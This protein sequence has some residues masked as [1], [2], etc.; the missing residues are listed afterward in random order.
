LIDYD[1]EMSGIPMPYT[2]PASLNVANTVEAMIN[3]GAIQLNIPTDKP[4]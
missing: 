4:Y 3:D 2:P 1:Y